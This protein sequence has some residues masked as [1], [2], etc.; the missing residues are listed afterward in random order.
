MHPLPVVVL[1]QNPETQSLP[2]GTSHPTGE[3]RALSWEGQSGVIM[4]HVVEP[5]PKYISLSSHH[6]I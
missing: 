6:I 3:P 1:E 2:N 4:G 5:P